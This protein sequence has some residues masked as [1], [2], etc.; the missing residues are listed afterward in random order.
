MSALDKKRVETI[1][2]KRQ[3]RW[4]IAG[5]DSRSILHYSVCV[6]ARWYGIRSTILARTVFFLLASCE[7]NEK[8][9]NWLKMTRFFCSSHTKFAPSSSSF[10]SPLDC[11]TQ[12]SDFLLISSNKKIW[13]ELSTTQGDRAHRCIESTA[14]GT[15]KKE[16]DATDSSWSTWHDDIE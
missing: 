2:R 15:L 5:L 10:V 8:S 16:F 4:F 9:G 14:I 3:S 1:N 11:I 7:D 6:D 13:S 12:L